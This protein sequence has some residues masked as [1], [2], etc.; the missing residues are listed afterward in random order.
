MTPF[1]RGTEGKQSVIHDQPE[2]HSDSRDSGS[3]PLQVSPETVQRLR[4]RFLIEPAARA[5][6]NQAP[7]HKESPS[8]TNQLD[9]APRSP[10]AELLGQLHGEIEILRDDVRFL[11]QELVGR[12]DETKS[13]LR[14]MELQAQTLHDLAAPRPDPARSGLA[15]KI[16]RNSRVWAVLAFVLVLLAVVYVVTLALGDDGT[17]P[18]A[19]HETAF[20]GSYRLLTWS[21][22]EPGML[23]P[24]IGVTGAAL[25]LEA[26]RGSWSVE[27]DS[28]ASPEAEPASLTCHAEL[29]AEQSPAVLELIDSEEAAAIAGAWDAA[30]SRSRDALWLTFCGRGLDG[31]SGAPFQIRREDSDE[32]GPVLVMDGAFATLLWASDVAAP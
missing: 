30:L 20:N 7:E 28:N 26:R 14:I 11:R 16:T 24:T 2:A 15:G 27:F 25:Y 9:R 13:Q 19:A 21:E 29:D 17:G 3:P 6:Q 10:T 5:S 32:Y 8:A 4:R 23:P 22:A 18:L 12:R 31:T 1:G